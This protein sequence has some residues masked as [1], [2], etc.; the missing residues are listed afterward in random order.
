VERY[1]EGV[2]P[3][4]GEP[5]PVDEELR[6]LTRSVAEEAA[7]CM[8]DLDFA[9]ALATVFRLIS[10][11][12]K[13]IDE[14]APWVL[15][16]DPEQKDRLATVLVYLLETVR[17]ATMLLAPAIPNIPALVWGQTGHEPE[18]CQSWEQLA[19]GGTKTGQKVKKGE[20][21]FPRIEVK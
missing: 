21:L 4:P 6:D 3:A 10:R 18:G 8:D 2:V 19:W 1:F 16:K 11:A 15:A 9:N 20:G 13:Y 14:T 17:I 7:G 12:N 5:Q